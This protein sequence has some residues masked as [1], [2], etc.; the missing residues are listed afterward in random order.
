MSV[1]CFVE[2]VFDKSNIK[3]C[4]HFQITSV[5]IRLTFQHI[6]TSKYS[7]KRF[8]HGEQIKLLNLKGNSIW[9]F[10]RMLQA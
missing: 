4:I 1:E 10:L 7:F 2:L 3:I 9:D 6:I 8:V 5:Q